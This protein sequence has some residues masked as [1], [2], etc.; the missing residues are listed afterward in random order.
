VQ[1]WYRIVSITSTSVAIMEPAYQGTTGGSKAY[2]LCKTDYLLPSELSDVA[3]IKFSYDGHLFVPGHQLQTADASWPPFSTGYPVSFSIFNQSQVYSTYTTGTVTGTSGSVSLTGI[4]TAWLSN[5]TP[6]DEI[7]INGDTNTYRVYSVT[8]DTAL[9]LYN[10]LT[11]A[12]TGATY[13]ASRQFGKVVRMWPCADQSYVCFFRGL[14]SYA[15]LVND[16]DVNELLLR[17]PHAVI[18][19]AVWREA[20]SSPD[21]REDSLYQKSEMMWAKAQGEDEQLFP[22]NTPSPIYDARQVGR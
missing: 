14:R 15:P 19:G 21:Q 4:G 17:Y 6:G 1:A 12:A 18:E 10:K 8:S 7:V 20:S 2:E 9:T 5:V 11:A 16:S 3:A 22:L 13:T